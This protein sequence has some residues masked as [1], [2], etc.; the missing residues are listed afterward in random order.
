MRR[1][2]SIGWLA[3]ACSPGPERAAGP[4]AV[5]EVPRAEGALEPG[6]ALP[7]RAEPVAPPPPDPLFAYIGIWDGRVNDTISTELVVERSGRFRVRAP[8]TSWRSECDLSGRFRASDRVVWMDVEQSSCSVI[9][10]GSTL[11]R[12][13]LSK[14]ERQFTV[15]SEDGSL[16]IRYTRRPD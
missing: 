16:V 2:I 10:V 7:P 11:E 15:E 4:P 14:S 1:G 12:S 6:H 3:I 8:A 9:T 13:V 5:V